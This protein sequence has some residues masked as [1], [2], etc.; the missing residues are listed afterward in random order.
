MNDTDT[1][2]LSA[3]II[4]ALQHHL[5]TDDY[6]PYDAQQAQEGLMRIHNSS[7]PEQNFRIRQLQTELQEVIN[8]EG[9]LILIN[10]DLK[11]A[12]KESENENAKLN[13]LLGEKDEEMD[14]LH[15]ELEE[16]YEADELLRKYKELEIIA[17]ELQDENKKEK[18]RSQRLFNQ[19]AETIQIQN[20]KKKYISRNALCLLCGESRYSSKRIR[21]KYGYCP[22][23]RDCFTCEKCGDKECARA[24]NTFNGEHISIG[25]IMLSK[26][27][28]DRE[29]I[30]RTMEL[31]NDKHTPSFLLTAYPN[32]TT[33]N[34][35]IDMINEWFRKS[36]EEPNE[37]FKLLSYYRDNLSI[38]NDTNL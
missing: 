18:E 21:D 2:Q 13:I 24:Y 8:N 17:K 38:C 28:E 37:I 15:K 5:P 25:E 20:W 12:L 3:G 32:L 4:F 27:D 26:H 33:D 14:K 11:D 19:H 35:I 36:I 7:Q 6:T 31:Y 30:K 34:E 16:K 1:L 10:E 23:L 22:L 9:E 29:E